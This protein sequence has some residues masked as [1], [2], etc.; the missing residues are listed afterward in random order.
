VVNG[1]QDADVYL[2][3]PGPTAGSMHLFINA[4]ATGAP[5][6]A[7]AGGVFA[8]FDINALDGDDT[9]ALDGMPT[10][11][12]DFDGGSG[13]NTIEYVSG[14]HTLAAVNPTADNVRVAA[15]A[16]LH[17]TTLDAID[18]LNV[19]GA[20]T[21]A[22]GGTTTL[23]VRSLDVT[24]TLDLAD[25]DLVIDYDGP[26]SPLGNWDGAAYTGLT[27]MI[28]AGRITSSVLTEVTGL[29]IAEAAAS[30]TLP[31]TQTALWSG[32]TVDASAVLIKYTY[33]GD[34]NLDGR[35]NVDDYGQI[36]FNI[37][38]PDPLLS[39]FIGDFNLDGKI[40][41]D[42]YGIIDF[43]VGAQTGAL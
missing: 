5:T 37:G 33:G 30:L 17:M 41:V 26:Q 3:R 8:G 36:D 40:N 1:S 10:M 21:V 39:Y 24:G 32:R 9:F 7:W 22:L 4:P 27:G 19:A 29:A 2:V 20:A 31:A 42:D 25:N 6:L 18:A 35:I 15:G 34:A 12:I 11:P 38:E 28:R 16:S 43:N 23:L 13:E 14:A